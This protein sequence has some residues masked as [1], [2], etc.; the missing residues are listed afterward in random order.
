MKRAF[1]EALRIEGSLCPG[2]AFQ[3]DLRGFTGVETEEE[4]RE[5]AL[6]LFIH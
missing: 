4:F 3:R 6:W 2:D 1:N 5:R